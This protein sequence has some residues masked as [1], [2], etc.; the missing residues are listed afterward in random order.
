MAQTISSDVKGDILIVDDDLASLRLLL[1]L[2]TEL[3]YEVRSVRDG[4]T[5][6]M[7][8]AADPPDLILLD[9]QMPDMDGYQVC[10]QLKNNNASRDIP[11]LFISAR[12]EVLDKVK[13]FEAGGVDYINKP[14]HADEIL[15][16][17][18]AHL[19]ITRLHTALIDTNLKLQAEILMREKTQLALRASE[20]SLRAQYQGIPIPTT[21][22]KRK[23]NDLILVDYNQAAA[24]NTRTNITDL[25]GVYAAE[26]FQDQGSIAEDM[27][28]C[29]AEKK[30]MERELDYTYKST[31]E[32]RSMSVKYAYVPPDLILV[33]YE[34]ITERKRAEK[35]LKKRLNEL[36]AL[37]QNSQTIATKRELPQALEIICKTIT[38]LFEACLT[39]I[40]LRANNSTELIGLIGFERTNGTIPFIRAESQLFNLSTL[41]E[42]HTGDISTVLTRL[43]S[44]P[45]PEPVREY[46]QLKSL[47]SGLIVPLT[48]RG[49]DLGI[50]ILAKDQN[51]ST[52]DKYEV[53]LAETIATDI[54]A[55]IE[56]D[57]LTEQARLAAVSAERQ[58]L[59][60]E[61]H[62]SVTQSIYSVTLLSSGWESMAR[63]GTLDDPADAFRRL[64]AVGQQALREMRLLL[65]Q[66]RPSILEEE[67][68]VNAL[69]QR[70]DTVEKRSNIDAQLIIRGDLRDLPQKIEDELFNIA[71]ESLNN[72]LRH[73]RAESIKVYIEEN[74]GALTLSIEDDGIGFDTSTKFTGMGLR[75]MQ[76]RAHA[77]GGE[78]SIYSATEYGTRVTISVDAHK[79]L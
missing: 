57:R 54:A 62:D 34:D 16:R 24:A 7:I 37:H 56:N 43:Q 50:L 4:S 79:V 20:A 22:W 10:K 2:L 41:L 69:Q 26:Y 72:S 60:R 23:G 75:N 76:E 18:K 31:G 11:V 46:V 1:N 52:F 13:G 27:F 35:Q 47:Q 66:L 33:H 55:A 73:A 40:A 39:V 51:D 15:A 25:L 6:L 32:T 67:G 3:G 65:H 36:S 12:D 28:L 21:T 48:S 49:V 29:I 78:L 74:Q 30:S 58:R 61:L 53:Q 5:A 17:I 64:G 70:L 63:Q 14:Y 38:D 77:I 8:V 45:F 19:T 42:L 9:V 68:L 71:Q 59:A 44:F